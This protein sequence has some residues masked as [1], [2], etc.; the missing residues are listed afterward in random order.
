MCQENKGKCPHPPDM[1]VVLNK[2][3][4]LE[5]PSPVGQH[6]EVGVYDATVWCTQCEAIQKETWESDPL[7]KGCFGP[8]VLLFEHHGDG[9]L[10]DGEGE[11]CQI[12]N[13]DEHR[14]Q[15]YAFEG[16]HQEDHPFICADPECDLFRKPQ[17][18]RTVV[19]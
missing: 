10:I 15:R 18:L 19:K 11:N 5:A 4:R 13:M 17:F 6:Y 9:Y 12:P 7:C 14:Q 3:S 16:P 1:V 8:M 2:L